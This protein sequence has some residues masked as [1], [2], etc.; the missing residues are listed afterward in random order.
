MAYDLRVHFGNH[1]NEPIFACTQPLDD[2]R[3]VRAS[4]GSF[5]DG[6]DDRVLLGA[7]GV[8]VTDN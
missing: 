7:R 3:F 8:F 1:G 5:I 6:A 2:V 4:K